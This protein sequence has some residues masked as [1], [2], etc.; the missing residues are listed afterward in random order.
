MKFFA[1][2]V[3]ASRYVLLAGAAHITT[4]DAREENVRVLREFLHGVD[5][6]RARAGK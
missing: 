6:T 4:W 5:S 1:D 2:S 3:P